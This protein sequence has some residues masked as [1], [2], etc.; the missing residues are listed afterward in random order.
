MASRANL[1]TGR[2]LHEG[3]IDYVH[4]PRSHIH[5]DTPTVASHLKK[6]GYVTGFIGKVHLGLGPKRWGFDEIP[7]TLPEIYQGGSKHIDPE[8]AVDG[9]QQIVK[10]HIT[11]IFA[12]AA[13]EF[14]DKHKEQR[15]FLWLATTAPHNPYY[16]FESHSYD[17]N[18]IKASPPPG[19]P[20]GK[21]LASAKE[22]VFDWAGY[23]STISMLDEQIGR[24]LKK[25]DDLELTSNT[26]V[27][28]S[29]DNGVMLGSH[30]H[31]GKT[32]WYEEATR[33]PAAVRW[34][35]RIEPGT[36]RDGFAGSVDL[37]P[38]ILEIAGIEGDRTL[39]G[40]SLVSLLTEGR[41]VRKFAFSEARRMIQ[42]GGGFWQMV[43]RDHWKYVEFTNRRIKHL[44]D[45][46]GDPHEATDLIGDPKHRGIQ[47]ELRNI[48]KQWRKPVGGGAA[49]E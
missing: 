11:Q 25:L 15:W 45:L 10:G 27:F 14:L 13:I 9:R 30:R 40:R 35:G 43:V 29:S 36:I 2:Y 49:S 42:R 20:D 6:A 19:W 34:P 24:I 21:R 7:V 4:P 1:L 23:Y 28:F 17:R 18:D 16:A 8:L 5:P 48:L 46:R 32:V 41:P 12:D 22:G 3:V 33:V 39:K 31:M 37:L 38:T 26:V 44:Y 47:E